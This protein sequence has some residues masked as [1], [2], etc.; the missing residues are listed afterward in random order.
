MHTTS[1]LWMTLTVGVFALIASTSQAQTLNAPELPVGFSLQYGASS[2]MPG[3]EA[4]QETTWDWSALPVVQVVALEFARRDSTV[5][6][7]M[8]PNA[9]HAQIV[10]GQTGA[11]YSY[12]GYDDVAMT[13]HG[14]IEGPTTL[15]Y[16]DPQIMMP[17]PFSDG[18]EHTSAVE[19]QWSTGGIFVQRYDSLS[20]K[21][22]GYGTLL[23]PYEGSYEVLRIEMHRAIRDSAITG[24]GWILVDGVG[25]WQDGMPLPVA[26]TYT[27]HQVLEG[28]TTFLFSG[29]ECLVDV[30]VGLEDES[31]S[32]SAPFLEM[33]PNPASDVLFMN[34]PAGAP[35]VVWNAAGEKVITRI[36]DGSQA[37]VDVSGWPAGMYVVRLGREVRRLI[38]Q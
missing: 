24:D 35:V 15:N 9:T 32:T 22:N 21:A 16:G 34:G 10:Q 5:F 17:Y 2:V 38:V 7:S 27:Y 12:L 37:S 23:D 31:V 29:A 1:T 3:A 11:N 13:Y 4:G 18:D 19:F 14:F 33:Y 25:F 36:L 20:M 26:Q 8:F 6:G 30:V 28:D